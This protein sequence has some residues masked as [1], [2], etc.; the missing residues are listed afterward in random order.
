MELCNGPF[1][2]DGVAGKGFVNQFQYP[3]KNGFDVGSGTM[4]R[5]SR[6]RRREEY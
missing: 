6:W 1:R 4:I 5:E 2:D 3:D